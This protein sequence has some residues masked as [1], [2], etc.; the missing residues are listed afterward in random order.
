MTEKP[1]VHVVDDEISVLRSIDFLLSTSGYSVRRWTDGPSFLKGADRSG[2]ACVLLDI[3][4]PEMDGLEVLAAMI[5]AGLDFPVIVLTGHGETNTAVSAMKLGAS[6]FFEK[7]FDA[8]KL[9][10]AIEHAFDSLRNRGQLLKHTQWAETQLGKLTQRER[11]V[12]DG[13]ACGLPNKSIAYDLGISSRTVEV[14]RA[15]IMTKLEV[16]SFAA[17]LRVAF[18]T[19]LGG[20]EA[21]D[22]A[23]RLARN[24]QGERAPAPIGMDVAG[25]TRSD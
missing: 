16:T 6:D 1:L 10:D 12:F 13:L 23:H 17:A 19:G 20:V 21:W 18:A 25:R 14:Y 8:P 9:L 3:S 2:E 24:Q 4:M 5:E 22:R 11:E 7:P 15:N